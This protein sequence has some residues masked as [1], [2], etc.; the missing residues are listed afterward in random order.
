MAE[1]KIR[2]GR[3]PRLN[4]GDEWNLYRYRKSGLAIKTCASMFRVSVPTANRIIAKFRAYDD[5]AEPLAREFPW[6]LVVG[7]SDRIAKL[8]TDIPGWD[9]HEHS[10][11]TQEEL[12]IVAALLEEAVP[13]LEAAA[14]REGRQLSGDAREVTHG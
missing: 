11:E 10:R 8:I 9:G 4:H 3:P 2:T 14:K 13:L 12:R 1:S 7:A 5:R 6:R